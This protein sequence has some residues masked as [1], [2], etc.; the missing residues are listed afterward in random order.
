MNN[1]IIN[2]LKNLSITHLYIC[3]ARKN[4]KK[5]LIGYNCLKFVQQVENKEG[6]P[7]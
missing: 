4:W 7:Y 1:K 6:K 2:K 5:I 3:K